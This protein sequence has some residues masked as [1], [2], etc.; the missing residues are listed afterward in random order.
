MSILTLAVGQSQ[1]SR[2]LIFVKSSFCLAPT[3]AE[4]QLWHL[5]TESRVAG[6]LWNP[7]SML[8]CHFCANTLATIETMIQLERWRPT[9]LNPALHWAGYSNMMTTAD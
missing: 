6:A 1:Y 9:P 4:I 5:V 8:F 7:N 3:V 2:I